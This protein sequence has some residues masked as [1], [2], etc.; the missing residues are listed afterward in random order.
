MEHH[1]S[2]SA[3]VRS[4][5][6]AILGSGQWIRALTE[7][8]GSLRF[9]SL[10]NPQCHFRVHGGISS[11]FYCH[12]IE[13]YV[14]VCEAG[15]MEPPPEV[16]GGLPQSHIVNL[17]SG[18][19]TLRFI[20]TPLSPSSVN[21]DAHEAVYLASRHGLHEDVEA[22]PPLFERVYQM[23]QMTPLTV[24][25]FEKRR[26]VRV[27]TA[28]IVVG[29]L[30]SVHAALD[31]LARQSVAPTADTLQQLARTPMSSLAACSVPPGAIHVLCIQIHATPDTGG[32]CLFATVRACRHIVDAMTQPGT[33]AACVAALISWPSLAKDAPLS[34][35][36][37]MHAR[38][39]CDAG[40]APWLPDAHV[41]G[42]LLPMGQLLVSLA[43]P[44]IRALTHGEPRDDADLAARMR[45]VAVPADKKQAHLS[46]WRLPT[47]AQQWSVPPRTFLRDV[48]WRV[49]QLGYTEYVWLTR[50]LT[51]WRTARD[52]GHLVNVPDLL[53]KLRPRN[54]PG[55]L[56]EYCHWCPQP[57]HP[58]TH[59]N[60]GDPWFHL[61]VQPLLR[62][63]PDT[64]RTRA[65]LSI[66]V[67]HLD[68]DRLIDRRVNEQRTLL[69]SAL[70]MGDPL[71]VSACA[72]GI[73]AAVTAV[74]Q[75]LV[76]VAVV[77]DTAG[78][79][80]TR[81][82]LAPISRLHE[83]GM[84]TQ[85]YM[86]VH[87]AVA[88]IERQFD[89]TARVDTD[90]AVAPRARA[91]GSAPLMVQHLVARERLATE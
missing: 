37:A 47:A 10:D 83:I 57:R 26:S 88:R 53:E 59:N 78:D 63:D 31:L 79:L 42:M 25:C 32:D 30:P 89:E 73:Y 2:V 84:N 24:E 81:V 75:L 7:I 82:E 85:L 60:T 48:P 69:G 86:N 36:L 17:T 35:T 50:F 72:F 21:A 22:S 87:D 54:H 11:S 33:R 71:A 34:P 55:A 90:A 28:D 77:T 76:A 80:V 39:C 61:S 18:P 14:C 68:V 3:P 27:S 41:F 67:D 6:A 49:Y 38:F 56:V 23:I 9:S 1:E 4:S 91:N 46:V 29:I 15:N 13:K 45:T 74:Q 51:Q 65:V 19:V 64:Q 40:F 58:F 62:F 20:G 70:K 12:C 52:A 43:A 66:V 16:D 8:Y 44:S 5:L